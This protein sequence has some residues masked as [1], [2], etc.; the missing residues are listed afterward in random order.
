MRCDEG[1]APPTV[2]LKFRYVGINNFFEDLQFCTVLL[3]VNYTH[4]R[5]KTITNEEVDEICNGTIVTYLNSISA[6]EV[7]F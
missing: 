3:G 4:E 7:E 1:Y 5:P 6:E 2:P